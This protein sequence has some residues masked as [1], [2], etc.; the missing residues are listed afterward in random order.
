M[1]RTVDPVQHAAKRLHIQNSAAHLFATQGFEATT[2]TQICHAA[3]ISTGNLYHYFTNKKQIFLAVLTDDDQYTAELLETLLPSADPV[4]AVLKFVAHLAAPA[5]VDPV[6]PQLAME[7]MLQAHRD[8]EVRAALDRSGAVEEVGLTK[9]LTGGVYTGRFRT[10]L[11]PEESAAWISAIISAVYLQ[12]AFDST[13]ATQSQ[14]A[15]L[16][17]TI[18]AYLTTQ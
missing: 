4:E 1:A 14:L 6:V 8:T 10:D 3:G 5:A 2:T 18:R 17:N 15:Q 7:A 12:A 11:D 9:L 16:H 13:A